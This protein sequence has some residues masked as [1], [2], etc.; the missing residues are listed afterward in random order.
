MSRLLGSMPDPEATY[1]T[2]AS[3]AETWRVPLAEVYRRAYRAG[4]RKT[5]TRPVG[6]LLADVYKTHGD[7]A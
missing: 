2:A 4:W 7:A 1:V 6:Y 3:L 5:P